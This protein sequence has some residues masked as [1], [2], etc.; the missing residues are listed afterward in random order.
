MI[1]RVIGINGVATTVIGILPAG[2]HF[3]SD[4]QVWNNG[5]RFF[6]R[7]ILSENPQIVGVVKD[8]KYAGLGRDAEPAIYF[9]SRQAPFGSVTLVVRTGASLSPESLINAL[10]RQLRDIDADLPLSHVQTL[11]EQVSESV[12][13]AR[14]QAVL[15]A[16][17]SL[18]AVCLG[19][20]GI[21]GVLSYTVVSTTREIGIRA[22]LRG[23]PSDILRLIVGQGLGLVGRGLALG[24]ALSLAAGRLIESLLFQGKPSDSSTYAW[25]CALL[26]GVGLL[27]GFFP[28][29]PHRV[30]I[31]ASRFE[32]RELGNCYF[33]KYESSIVTCA[34]FRILSMA[35]RVN[36][37]PSCFSIS[38]LACSKFLEVRS[39]T[40]MR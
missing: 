17:F 1:G 27:A 19:S 14:F 40:L 39:S 7:R 29:G 38:G 16:A 15:L 5:I 11:N 26:T 13:Q 24:I 22:A 34:C 4:A 9:P 32:T 35:S 23:R 2:I 31:R 37:G 6:R 36:C 25:V 20:I 28:P 10:R 18:L 3:A 30:S 33:P 21:Y 8:M 12:A